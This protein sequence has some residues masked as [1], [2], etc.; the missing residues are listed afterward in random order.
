MNRLMRFAIP[1][2]AVC[3][4]A[5][6]VRAS[7]AGKSK[8]LPAATVK[9]L[10]ATMLTVTADGKDTT[11]A[12][13]AKTSVIGKGVG[14][15]AA[16]KAG[17]ATITDLLGVGDRV[18]VTYQDAG[19]DA[20]VEGRA[21]GEAR[22]GRRHLVDA[23]RIRTLRRA[24][25]RRARGDETGVAQGA[26]RDRGT[27]DRRDQS[28]RE[29]RRRDLSGPDRRPRR[30]HARRRPLPRRAVSDEGRVRPRGRP[31]DRIRQPAVPRHDRA[32]RHASVRAVQSVGRQHSRPLGRARVFDVRH[33]RERS[34][35]ATRPPPGSTAIQPADRRAAAWPR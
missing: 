33:D 32:S 19:G 25:S 35:S 2:L 22:A 17:K 13:D 8:L 26:R 29:R 12:V 30:D 4:L 14:T 24:W 6:P 9:S 5:L 31:P 21:A 34:C 1:V 11:F 10:T 27:G 28:I 20:R 7:A 3:V 15:K 23:I 18:T 16:P